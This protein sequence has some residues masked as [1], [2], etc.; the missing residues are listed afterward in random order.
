MTIKI[1]SIHF[2]ADKKLIAFIEERVNK[3]S[4]F[5]DGIVSSEVYLKLEKSSNT[6]NKIVEIK[7][8]IPGSDIFASKHNK[9]F[10]EAVT[11]TI[12]ALE[13]QLKKHKERIKGL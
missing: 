1:Q 8:M 5:Y 4:H 6:E 3:L 11:G 12:D 10:E 13:S 7:L 2:D 9:T